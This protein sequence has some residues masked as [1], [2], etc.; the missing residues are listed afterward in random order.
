MLVSWSGLDLIRRKNAKVNVFYYMH[1]IYR[2]LAQ[3]L[4]NDDDDDDDDE[5]KQASKQSDNLRLFSAEDDGTALRRNHG[6][7]KNTNRHL[8]NSDSVRATMVQ[9]KDN[10]LKR[11]CVSRDSGPA[12]L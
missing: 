1:D 5:C 11:C 7:D 2:H 12:S 9:V 6:T 4:I 10:M 3:L 8:H